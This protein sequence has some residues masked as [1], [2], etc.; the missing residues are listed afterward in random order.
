M[1]KLNEGQCIRSFT[2]HLNEKNFV[3]LETH[4]GYIV[5]GSENNTCYLYCNELSKPIL[6]YKFDDGIKKIF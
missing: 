5:T 6:N 3:G 4:N 2:G 1:W